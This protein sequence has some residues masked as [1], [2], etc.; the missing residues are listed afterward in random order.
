MGLREGVEDGRRGGWAAEVGEDGPAEEEAS[1]V[2][3]PCPSAVAI[4]EEEGTG[5]GRI[6]VSGER[7]S[8]KRSPASLR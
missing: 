7:L 4:V 2:G 3:R 1:E 5:Q 8:S 6:G